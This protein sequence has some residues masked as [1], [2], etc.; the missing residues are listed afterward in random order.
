MKWRQIEWSRRN[1]NFNEVDRVVEMLQN[2]N[3]PIRGHTV[4]WG[5]DQYVP[6]WLK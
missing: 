1:R 2:K 4:L 3:I 6:K 5:V